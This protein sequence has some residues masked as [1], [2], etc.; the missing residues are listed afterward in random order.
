[1]DSFKDSGLKMKNKIDELEATIV[2]LSKDKDYHEK[3]A[4]RFEKL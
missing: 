4:D 2:Q 1:M 3:L